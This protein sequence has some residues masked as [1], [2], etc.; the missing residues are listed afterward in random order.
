MTTARRTTLALLL[1]AALG[2]CVAYYP[3]HPTTAPGPSKFDQAFDA[4]VNA[5][6]DSGVTVTSADRAS[7]RIIGSKAGVP[8]SIDL[9][10]QGDGSVRIAFNAP[11]S[12]QSNPTLPEQ[13]NN[14]Y[15][16]RMGR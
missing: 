8:V 10:R 7:G 5:A 13:L 4:A 16:R 1:A 15:Q 12:R 3:T 11:D 9:M 2:G 6:A 14:A